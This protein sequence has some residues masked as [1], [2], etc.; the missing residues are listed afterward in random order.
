MQIYLSSP[1][2]S[3]EGN[4]A[5]SPHQ[6]Q[7]QCQAQTLAHHTPSG[8]QLT[9]KNADRTRLHK[10]PFSDTTV[11]ESQRSFGV[12]LH[13]ESTVLQE[14]GPARKH[15]HIEQARENLETPT[16][17]QASTHSHQFQ[18]ENGQQRVDTSLGQQRTQGDVNTRWLP[19]TD[20][21][22]LD[23]YTL[24]RKLGEG[25][26]N[27]VMKC[28]HKETGKEYAVKQL[29]D[30]TAARAELETHL[31]CHEH[32]LIISVIEVFQQSTPPS[33]PKLLP[34][35]RMFGQSRRGR[36]TGE[37]DAETGWLILV[38]ELAQGGDLFDRL[39]S[40]PGGRFT[41]VCSH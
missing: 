32:P 33:P 13:P 34:A 26:G 22:F 40:S 17:V 28:V 38:L 31:L 16:L 19:R 14:M 37:A 5:A 36:S 6:S 10:L 21:S 1:T 11:D 4:T 18:N 25:Q 15:R 24:N 27:A 23:V 29:R 35:R 20:A 8:K 3:T 7:D 9:D 12:C 2:A 41:E 39:T 30:T